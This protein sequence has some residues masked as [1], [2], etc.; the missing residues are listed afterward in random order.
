MYEQGRFQI[1][2]MMGL[3]MGLLATIGIIYP[4]ICDEEIRVCME[5][6]RMTGWMD[7]ELRR[8]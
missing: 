3:M 5:A 2:W 4:S 1:P 8:G 6:E 7:G